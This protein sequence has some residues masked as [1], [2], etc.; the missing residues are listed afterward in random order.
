MIAVPNYISPE[1]YLD[2]E[3]QTPI[4]HEYRRGL[5]YAIAGGTDNHDR[6]AQNLLYL[7][8]LHLRDSSDCRFYS[9]NVKVNYQ[10]EFYYYPD[11]FVTCDSR[12]RSDRYVKRYPKLIAEVLSPST[13]TFD[14][15]GKFTDYQKIDTLEEYILISQE[16]QRVECHRLTGTDTWETQVYG[17]GDRIIL[18]S[19][20]LEFAMGELYL[21][22][23]P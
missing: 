10:D 9:G 19:L 14:L 17:E 16:T 8:N 7:I 2:I 3:R 21:G 13:Q 1:E 15:G 4:R 6:I 11:A 18:K 5:V 22:L 12:D 23:D 20:E